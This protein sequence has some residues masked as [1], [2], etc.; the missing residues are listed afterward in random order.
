MTASRSRW[1]ASSSRS[2]FWRCASGTLV[3]AIV[4]ATCAVWW[5][6]SETIAL[7][8]CSCSAISC[9]SRCRSNSWTC[10]GSATLA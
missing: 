1:R 9:R 10:G 4:C 5:A 6:C 7:R 3:F 8:C 2:I